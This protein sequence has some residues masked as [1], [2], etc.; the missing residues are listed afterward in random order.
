MKIAVAK[1]YILL[2]LAMIFWGGSWV[3]AQIVVSVAPPMTVG[4]F[5]FFTASLIFLPLFL[6]TQR[7]SL[8]TY[9]ARDFKLFFVLGLIGVFGYGILFLIGMQFTTA[10]QGSIIAGINPVTVSLLAF[11][12]LQ[13]RL[14]P[15]WRYTGFL[16]SFLGIVFVVGV[17]S[18][19]D[20][21]LE[22]LIGNVILICAMFTWGSYSILG[23]S[24]MKK[25]SSIETTAMGIFFGTL[26]FFVGALFEQFW[27]LPIMYDPTFWLNILYMGLFVTVLGFLFY[28]L[29]IK[30]LGASK[31]A[32]FISMVPVFGTLFSFLLLHEP[33][34]PTFLIGLILVI[35]GILF[36]NYPLKTQVTDVQPSPTQLDE[37]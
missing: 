27:T 36:I 15:K 32:V 9:T 22:Y 34:Y 2:I 5:R 7:K 1:Y 14:T 28:F 10:A 3:S 25:R 6:A 30:N 4:F 33:I 8:R 23:K 24:V 11:L 17:Q 35:V 13:E 37:S 18:L 26:I 19:L 31:S 20:F 29:G 21:H 16:F 12:I